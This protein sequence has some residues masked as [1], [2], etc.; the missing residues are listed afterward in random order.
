VQSLDPAN[1]AQAQLLAQLLA[2]QSAFSTAHPADADTTADKSASDIA[3]EKADLQDQLNKLTLTS[4]QLTALQRDALDDSNKALFD[5][6]QAAQAAKDAIT[7]QNSVLDQQ[8]QLYAATGDAAGAAAVLEQQHAAALVGLS[9]ALAAATQAT[10]DAQAA[11]KAKADALAESNSVL[12]LQSQLY[13]L[14]GD[15]AGAAAVLEQ[16][17]AAALVGLTPAVAAA[18]QALWD[19]QAAEKTKS[20]ALTISNS[21][22]DIQA[23]I[24]QV[25]GNKAGAAAVL[26]QQHIAALAAMDPALRGA[27]EQL[28]A[29]QAAADA[30]NGFA[31]GIQATVD[32]AKTAIDTFK[33]FKDS[34]YVGDQSPLSKQDQYTVAK[35]QLQS[36]GPDDI[37]S[38]AT[39]FLNAAK[40]TDSVIQYAKDFAAVQAA[41][42]SA[43]AGRK[44]AIANAG[45]FAQTFAQTL[46]G[47]GIGAHA[48]GGI[49]SGLSLVGEQGPE[50]VDFRQSAR[51]YTASQTSGMLGGAG[52][53]QALLD[54]ID[55]LISKTD[56][57]HGESKKAT[58]HA[59]ST[60]E[61][62]RR[63]T[64]D[65]NSLQTSA[66]K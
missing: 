43:I 54:R 30:L 42:D 47:A 63:V 56:Q 66:A 36:A 45:S 24:Y 41:L 65:G 15:K 49:A 25:T 7:D 40:A 12:D 26:E 9:P 37:Q 21:L 48:N 50:L 60:S 58:A 31:Q 10:W 11:E 16:Q 61:I 22:L 18:T 52:N 4:T 2:L 64:K 1:A 53:N 33:K 19:Q 3:S 5:Q 34:L 23:Q 8:A 14:T 59:R 51:V 17:H 44:G 20:D 27:T 13:A 32:A 46:A 35:A 62:L 29:V 38:A 57:L 55:T 39:T 6:V 28:Y